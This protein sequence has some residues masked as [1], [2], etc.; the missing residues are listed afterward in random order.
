MDPAWRGAENGYETTQEAVSVI[1][2]T[3]MFR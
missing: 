2:V 1:S 3:F